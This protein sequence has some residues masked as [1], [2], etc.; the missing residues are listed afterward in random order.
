MSG[1]GLAFTA[2]SELAGASWAGRAM[3]AQNTAQ[4]AVGAA[5]PGVIGALITGSG[6]GIAFAVAGGLA[7]AAAFVTLRERRAPA[8][9]TAPTT[10]P[11]SQPESPVPAASAPHPRRTVR[12]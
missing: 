1:N 7:L 2:V 3:G 4:N 10:S 6:F 11:V 12:A 8:V 5:T 9:Q